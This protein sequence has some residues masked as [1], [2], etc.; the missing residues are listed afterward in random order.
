MPGGGA[1]VGCGWVT[2]VEGS[3]KGGALSSRFQFKEAATMLA[4]V[5]WGE[6]EE[7]GC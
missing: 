7:D 5:R 4:P 2:S 6:E 3:I 1:G